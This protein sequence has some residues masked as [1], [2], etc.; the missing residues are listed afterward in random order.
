MSLHRGRKTFKQNNPKPCQRT[1]PGC[2]NRRRRMRFEKFPEAP[3]QLSMDD[4]VRM[5]FRFYLHFSRIIFRVSLCG[6][7]VFVL[8]CTIYEI[9][10]K[11]FSLKPNQG[12]LS[13]SA[14]SNSKFLFSSHSTEQELD[15]LNGIRSLSILWVILGHRY[16]LTMYVPIV[17]GLDI[18]DVCT[19]KVNLFF[20]F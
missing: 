20:F 12:L 9:F 11:R 16:F 13:F 10:V 3:K 17:N 19:S 4:I 8:L 18:L 15:C 6:L 7:M 14:Y 5:F 2:F 1:R